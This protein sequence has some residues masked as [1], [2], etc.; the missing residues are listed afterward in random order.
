MHRIDPKTP[1]GL[2]ALFR[3]DGTPLPF[4]SAHRGG[5]GVGW[6]ENCIAT[7]E[8]TLQ[9]GP[10]ALEIDPRYTKDGFIVL[11][12]DET[13][14]RT[15]TGAGRVRDHTLAELRKLHLK[16]RDGNVTP[17][18]IPTLEE[19]IEWARGKT[20]LVLD[21]KDVSA[22]ERA[23][24]VAEHHAEAFVMLIVPKLD[25]AK[26]VHAMNP[27]IFME[28]MVPNRERV[29]E[30]D[31][32][33][34]PWSNLVAFVGHQPSE[35]LDLY[36]MIH[37]RGACCMIG[38]SRNLDRKILRGE[39]K[40]IRSLVKDYR[41]FIERGADIVETD[42]PVELSGLLSGWVTVTEGKRGYFP[43]R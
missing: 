36:R 29:A 43:G 35:D 2:R 12:H 31:S 33:G 20:I 16:D 27:D 25:D 9:S 30:F 34:V 1:A 38:T 4:L 23:K 28:V 15:T 8:R 21:K 7:F 10:A 6:P 22:T 37:E 19:A 13:L 42:I 40:D 17:H 24:F 32:S 11:H 14:E 5:A 18:R 41:A 3:H 39:V 26:A